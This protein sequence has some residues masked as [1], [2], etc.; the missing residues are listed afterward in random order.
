MGA[1]LAAALATTAG[2]TGLIAW[3]AAIARDDPGRSEE[4]YGQRC[5]HDGCGG[6]WRAGAGCGADGAGPAGG[7]SA[8]SCRALFLPGDAAP[9]SHFCALPLLFAPDAV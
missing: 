9:H 2:A 5:C 1:A 4:R 8:V 7:H 6:G 3:A